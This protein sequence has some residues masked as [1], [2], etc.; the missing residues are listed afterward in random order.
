MK[1]VLTDSEFKAVCGVISSLTGLEFPANRKTTLGRNLSLAAK[2][3]GYSELGEFVNW[4]LTADL[5]RDQ[6]ERLAEYLTI[7]E[8]YFWRESN[9]FAAF[10]DHIL[11]ELIA[12]KKE[13]KN[14]RIWCAGC[15]TGEEPYSLAIALNRAIPD[16]NNW[17]IKILATD[18]NPW[19]LDKAITGVYTKWSFRNCPTWFQSSY[20]Q[21]LGNEK[22]EILPRIR[23]MVSFTNL[24]LI[25][26]TY[27]SFMNDTHSMDIIFC[28]NVLMYFSE[29]WANK[30]SHKLFDSLNKNGWFVVAAC[31]LS[32]QVFSQFETVNFQEAIVYRKS[33][34]EAAINDNVDVDQQKPG[35]RSATSGKDNPYIIADL[36]PEVLSPALKD[37]KSP[38]VIE[39]ITSPSNAAIVDSVENIRLL[40]NGGQLQEALALCDGCI[41][42]DKL[43]IR[44]Y[45]LRAS[46]LQELD[47]HHDAILSLKHAV[48]LDP[49]FIMG[50][51][52]LG[53]LYLR[54]EKMNAAR[55]H[56]NNVLDLI[57]N[58]K[59]DEIIPESE[60]LSVKYVSD[61]I[62]N[63][64]Q[65]L[66]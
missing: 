48:Y 5:K 25:D 47:N 53:N 11:P 22:Y 27:P 54:Q 13:D 16:I 38:M 2:E 41:K 15:S 58:M 4:L 23:K 39:E 43:S 65:K 9:V 24:N 61:I 37:A 7:T 63:N 1:A 10:T 33:R 35:P 14:I 31:E 60:G 51:F 34:K 50:H 18:L 28:R 40:A 20:F 66:K 64:M 46:I 3:F 45:S 55:L 8:T 21:N 42:K 62:I 12:S 19:A 26:D 30:I 52:A 17:K 32:S 49:N 29:E 36:E 6:V 59:Q 57:R 44:L 56:F